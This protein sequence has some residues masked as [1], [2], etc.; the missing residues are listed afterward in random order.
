MKK[1]NRRKNKLHLHNVGRI[2]I[3]LSAWFIK[4][5]TE[6]MKR[7][8]S[9]VKNR[10]LKELKKQL[11]L[12][13]KKHL[14]LDISKVKIYHFIQI[15]E[16]NHN[17]LKSYKLLYVPKKWLK[18]QADEIINISFERLELSKVDK[19]KQF[20][21]E[22]VSKTA[23]LMALRMLGV[24]LETKERYEF[25]KDLSVI[26]MKILRRFNIKLEDE[27]LLNNIKRQITN[28][29]RDLHRI[30][31]IADTEKQRILQEAENN[32]VTPTEAIMSLLHAITNTVDRNMYL[33]DFFVIYQNHKKQI[34]NEK[35][36]SRNI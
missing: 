18:L 20:Q 34:K 9:F 13:L 26:A 29:E 23:I 11:K 33:L 7:V 27:N 15:M 4:S 14:I 36:N 10:I 3:P 32:N 21:N 8:F 19:S 2:L 31:I 6:V 22:I 1:E 28:I 5:V 16:G 30:T 12:Y 25:N 24:I 17:Y 35:Q